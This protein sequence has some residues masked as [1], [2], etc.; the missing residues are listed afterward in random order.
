MTVK[1]RQEEKTGGKRYM[2]QPR[3][4]ESKLTLPSIPMQIS[5]V[6][7]LARDQIYSDSFYPFS[8]AMRKQK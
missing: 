8:A 5:E 1:F 7:A 6:F 3:Q 2:N 4:R